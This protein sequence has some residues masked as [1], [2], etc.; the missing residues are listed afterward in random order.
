MNSIKWSSK[1]SLAVLLVSL[2]PLATLI[3]VALKIRLPENGRM[4]WSI[5]NIV[6]ILTGLLL[7][8]IAMKQK[9]S[10]DP[11]LILA[12]LTSIVLLLMVLGIVALSVVL[13]IIG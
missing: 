7:S 9:K 13:N 11:I 6:L 2:L 10:R 4:I 5:C 3:P 8:G 1:R 12:L